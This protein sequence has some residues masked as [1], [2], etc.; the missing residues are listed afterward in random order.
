MLRVALGRARPDTEWSGKVSGLEFSPNPG[1]GARAHASELT[2]WSRS[3][4]TGTGAGG[5]FETSTILTAPRD[6]FEQEIDLEVG[7]AATG[8]GNLDTSSKDTESA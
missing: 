6:H 7:D 8:K 5:G 4:A 2:G 3:R 1:H